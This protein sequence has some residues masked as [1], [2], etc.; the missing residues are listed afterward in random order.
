MRKFSIW[1]MGLFFI[2]SLNLANAQNS[3]SGTVKS[4]DD[5]STLPGVSVVIQGTSLGTTTDMDG[6]YVISV[7]DG[8]TALVFSFVGMEKQTIPY[9]GQSVID[10]VMQS[11]SL[12]LDEVVVTAIGI[13][14][15]KKELGYNVQTVNADQIASKPNA[16]VV[17]SLAGRTSGVQITSS[18]GDAG[19]STYITIRGAASITGNNQPLFV[20]NGMPIISGGGDSGVGGV[21]TSSRS[22][23]LNPEDIESITVLKGGAAT[24]LYGVRAANGALVITTKSGKKLEARKIEFHTSV[25]FD[26]VSQLPARQKIYSQGYNGAW[27]GGN[28]M[29]FG[30]KIA[31][32]EYDG[33]ANYKWDPFG[34]LVAKGTGNGMPAQYYDPYEFFQTG[35]S[36]NNRLS[37]SNGNE[38]G[39]FYF[40]MSNLEQDGVVPNNHYGRTTLRLNASNKLTEKITMGADFAYTNSVATQIQK[41]SNVSGIML[42]LLR[43]ASTFDN[44]AGYMFPDGTQRNYRNG[45]GYDNPYWTANRIAYDENVNR[46]TG[47]GNVNVRFNDFVSLS[48]NAGVDWYTRRY[49]N[50]FAI[51]SRAYPTGYMDEY[52]NYAGIFN[53]D[54]LLN[55]QK[56]LSE[57]LNIKVTLGNNMYSSFSKYLYGDAT[58][59]QIP[60]F[61]QLSNSA[62][63]TVSTAISNY[64]TM[65]VFAD[66]HLAYNNMLYLGVTGR[67][68]WST[69]MPEANLSAFYPSV[70]FGFVF[71]ELEAL[72]GNN[73]LSYGKIRASAARTANIAGAYNTSNYFYAASTA[74][75]WTNG[76]QFPY[77]TYTGFALGAGLGNP[78]LKHETMD[79]WEVGID[80]RLFQNRLGIDFSYFNNL[81]KDLL[82]PVPIAASTGFTSVFMNAATM[83]SKG[84]ELSLDLDAVK[85]TNFQ[86]NI[87]ANFTKMTNTVVSLAEGV[88]NLFLGG[89]TVPQVRAVAGQ[90]YGSIFG[91]DWY[92]DENGNVL[93]ND[94]PTDSYRDGYPWQDTRS[95]VPIGNVNPDWTANITNTLTYKKLSFSFMWDIKSGGMMYNGTGFAMNYFGTSAA[96][97]TREVYYTPE[98]T[99][100]FDL[101]PA[102]N[103]VVL[104]GVYGHLDANGNPVG[105]GV[106]NT[107]PVVLDQA[108]YT[109]GGG[110]N[111]ASGPSVAAMQDASWLRL[112][113]ITL[114]YDLPVK[115]TFIKNAQIYF[116]GKNLLLFTP[117]TGID[118]E[119][120]LEGAQN[121]QGMDYFN[122]P[123]SK[124]YMFGLKVTF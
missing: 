56:D 73:I 12:A 37:V 49:Q 114:S 109:S 47:S 60:D 26:Q 32:L 111:F 44:S 15:E 55:F 77:Q 100:D 63:N 80:A 104:D 121:G 110:S 36:T 101:T 62:N 27:A 113:D 122:N 103:I 59:L 19:A 108:W 69:T 76:V 13:S 29:S 83:E 70:S 24:A 105:T 34:R 43:T 40:S 92:R 31:D 75:G 10:V 17:N 28:S 61:Y 4:A 51:N 119:T 35:I 116:T 91:N 87:V 33:D 7:P 42:G 30:A 97:A 53:S 16:D 123:G 41:G 118:P 22:I 94:D 84:I 74:D 6:K 81:N 88:D 93:I 115:N 5:G 25:G 107:T 50:R 57:K 72:K 48:Y 66:V 9:T 65:A 90:E 18:A 11:S 23:D 79:S 112:R 71:T 67:N 86:W 64:R 95:M 54:L 20:V 89:F 85:T 58:V 39:S 98:G 38:Q 1:L 120:N 124:T 82:M 68:D 46:F 45:G 2:T 102:E 14:R 21:S 99:I 96:T 106:T 78:D 3:V 117:Y 52:Q 8:S